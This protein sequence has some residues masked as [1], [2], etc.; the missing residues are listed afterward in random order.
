MRHFFY[1]RAKFT[2]TR[3]NQIKT[4]PYSSHKSTRKKMYEFDLIVQEFFTCE[5]HF[6]FVPFSL[7]QPSSQAKMIINDRR[8]AQRFGFS[9]GVNSSTGSEWNVYRNACRGTQ[10]RHRGRND[11]RRPIAH[12][13]PSLIPRYIFTANRRSFHFDR[14]NLVY[15]SRYAVYA[16][17]ISRWKLSDP[18][19]GRFQASPSFYLNGM[20]A[21]TPPILNFHPPRRDASRLTATF[22]RK[23]HCFASHRFVS[24]CPKH[25]VRELALFPVTQISIVINRSE[26]IISN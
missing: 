8:N 13:S 18:S 7:S 19:I 25:R 22:P 21:S 15:L 6:P 17:L 12:R 4:I 5:Q 20:S 14:H 11:K 1:L 10:R 9:T 24:K 3:S 2:H 16:N 23:K 26:T